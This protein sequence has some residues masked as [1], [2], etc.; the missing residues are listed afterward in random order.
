MQPRCGSNI[1]TYIMHGCCLWRLM[2]A[3]MVTP[4]TSTCSAAV[5]RP[6]PPNAGTLSGTIGP[7]LKPC[8]RM[9]TTRTLTGL[10]NPTSMDHRNPGREAGATSP[11]PNPPAARPR[12]V[13]CAP[14]WRQV[15]APA[16][17]PQPQKINAPAPSHPSKMAPKRVRFAV[18][19]ERC[20][21]CSQTCRTLRKQQRR[22]DA[23]LQQLR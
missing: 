4:S 2:E 11:P 1:R 10:P 16:A 21:D 12:P 15:R 5:K 18:E 19:E 14:C 7:D 8:A 3:M 9:A 6:S 22:L 20:E 17:A 23:Q 13:S